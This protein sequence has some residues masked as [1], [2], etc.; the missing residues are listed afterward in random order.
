MVNEGSHMCIDRTM[1]IY[2][3][4][5]VLLVFNSIFIVGKLINEL[6][7]Q[8]GF[9]YRW[10]RFKLQTTLL[11]ALESVM[12]YTLFLFSTVGQFE[13]FAIIGAWFT[14]KILPKVWESKIEQG[15]S[16]YIV[17]GFNDAKQVEENKALN[18]WAGEKYNIFLFGNL[19]SVA[20]AYGLSLLTHYVK[21][22]QNVNTC[23]TTFISVCLY[24]ILNIIIVHWIKTTPSRERNIKILSKKK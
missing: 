4:G 8:A 20:T 18:T 23:L 14:I 3:L 16:D 5:Y 1:L 24:G 10:E 12:Y 7:E 13:K 15:K 17:I 21:S 2:L 6:W 9:E 11:G 19:Y 22:S